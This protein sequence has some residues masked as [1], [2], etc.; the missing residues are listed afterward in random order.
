VRNTSI[1]LQSAGKC[2]T[3]ENLSGASLKKF[4]CENLSGL[5]LLPSHDQIVFAGDSLSLRC[6]GI[7]LYGRVEWIWG[8]KDPQAEF[9][10]T[11][12]EKT[13]AEHGIIESWIRIEK[14]LPEHSGDW[15]CHQVTGGNR[16]STLS[17]LVVSDTTQYCPFVTSRDSKGTY[18]W[19]KTV[20]GHDVD[21]PCVV[22]HPGIKLAYASYSCAKD[23]E[24]YDLNTSACPYVSET[25]QILENYAAENASSGVETMYDKAKILFNITSQLRN[26]TDPMDIVFVSQTVEKYS[27]H[28]STIPDLSYVLVDVISKLSKASQYLLSA[29]QE[30]GRACSRLRTTLETIAET[31]PDFYT[32]RDSLAIQEFSVTVDSFS[33]LA[34]AWRRDKDEARRF[35]CITNG[36]A[37]LDGFDRDLLALVELPGSLFSGMDPSSSQLVVSMFSNSNF[38]PDLTLLGNSFISSTV[39][40]NIGNY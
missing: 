33:G 20:I 25:T 11:V 13:V 24:W 7:G 16:S 36:R 27:R 29:A 6:R 40:V 17:V 5:E 19:P 2:A 10:V 34:C 31:T 9:E 12:T 39:G 28:I 8:S 26:L 15:R 21:L 23:G 30:R 35:H 1:K 32:H 3:P 22:D 37:L 4:E 38:F 18:F 14:L